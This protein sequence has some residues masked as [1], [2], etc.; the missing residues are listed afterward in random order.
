MPDALVS[1]ADS[2]PPPARSSV[3]VHPVRSSAPD[4]VAASATARA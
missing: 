3:T 2:A 4:R 1:T